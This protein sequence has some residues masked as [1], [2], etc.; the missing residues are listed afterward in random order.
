[1]SV[2]ENIL[3]SVGFVIASILMAFVIKLIVLPVLA[4]VA[5]FIFSIYDTVHAKRFR[6]AMD[7]LQVA[8]SQEQD[9]KRKVNNMLNRDAAGL[10]SLMLLFMTGNADRFERLPNHAARVQFIEGQVEA[11]G[12]ARALYLGSYK[13]A[14]NT[15]TSRKM[16]DETGKGSLVSIPANVSVK[17]VF[18]R[19]NKDTVS[20]QKA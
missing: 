19:L 5:D 1:M 11:A 7:A 13:S 6:K 14:L 8:K 10:S 16:K 2:F 17:S 9:E 12:F 18:A 4:F 20:L 15:Y 3:F